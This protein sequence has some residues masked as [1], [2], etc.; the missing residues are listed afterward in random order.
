MQTPQESP[1]TSGK[2]LVIKTN[3]PVEL[4]RGSLAENI[5]Q[6]HIFELVTFDGGLGVEDVEMLRAA[7]VSGPL[8]LGEEK[9]GIDFAQEFDY[10]TSET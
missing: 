6:L 7:P 2:T 1:R 8:T 4:D 9:A 5:I 10:L 3:R